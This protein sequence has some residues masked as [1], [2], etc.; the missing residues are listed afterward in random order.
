MEKAVNGELG[1]FGV[2]FLVPLFLT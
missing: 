2:L 1:D